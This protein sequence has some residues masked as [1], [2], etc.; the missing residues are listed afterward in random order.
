GE[1]IS[2]GQFLGSL[3]IN[4][5][6]GTDLLRVT[7]RS[8]EPEMAEAAVDALM[9]VYQQQHLLDNRAEAVAAREFIEQQLPD[10]ERRAL[11]AE[12]A[13][14]NFKERNQIVALEPETL[15]TVT[16]LDEIAEQITEVN[17]QLS[18]AEAQFNTIQARIG[19]DPQSAL[20]TTAISQAEGVQALLRE[21]QEVEVA[22]AAERVR[23]QD[24]HPTVIDLSNKLNN[25]ESLLNQQISSVIGTQVLPSG[26]ST[27]FN[28]QVGDVE[29]SLVKEYLRLEAS[30]NGLQEQALILEDAQL[31]YSSRASVLPQLEQEQN[32]LERKLEAAQST[33]SLLLRRLQEVRVAENQNVGNVRVVQPASLLA[34]P[35]SPNRRLYLA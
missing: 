35:V 20:V 23:F 25:I 24:Q 30:V 32:E 15:A 29:S 17:A 4:N 11:S 16:S 7:Y 21:Y 28:L 13:L 5:E 12:A 14:R 33:Y 3:S 34:G 31:A 18:S 26:I 6:S 8:T 22:L 19:K 9:T 2:H 27:G 10:A 1:L